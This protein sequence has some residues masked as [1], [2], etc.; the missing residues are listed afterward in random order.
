MI[1]QSNKIKYDNKNKQTT[2][3]KAHYLTN[4]II[5]LWTI[6][7]IRSLIG[8][9]LNNIQKLGS[10]VV[11]VTTN[12]FITNL[13]NL[14]DSIISNIKYQNSNYLLTKYR[15]LK[16]DLFNNKT[17][18]EL[19]NISSGIIS[20]SIQGQVGLESELRATTGFQN[21]FYTQSE[22]IKLFTNQIEFGNDLRQ[23]EYLQ[24]LLRSAIDIIKH[25]GHVTKKY[26][27]QRFSLVYNNSFSEASSLKHFTTG[28]GASILTSFSSSISTRFLLIRF[29]WASVSIRNLTYII[30]EGHEK[31]KIQSLEQICEK[32]Y[33]GKVIY[34]KE[35]SSTLPIISFLR[36]DMNVWKDSGFIARVSFFIEVICHKG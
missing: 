13:E 14:E 12:G 5:A 34:S 22:L 26:K 16:E 24:T 1:S 35:A 27:D 17:S 11:S 33:I 20:W 19:K 15:T 21:K 4:P 36:I 28:Y 7:Y 30:G 10:L 23:I 6:A 2:Q 32:Q 18:L 29:I 3:I 8:E 9:Y 25:R 31:E